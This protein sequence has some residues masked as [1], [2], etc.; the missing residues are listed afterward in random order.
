[1]K[2]I[3]GAFDGLLQCLTF[4]MFYGF[5]VVVWQHNDVDFVRC[6]AI[7]APINDKRRSVSV[8]DVEPSR[9]QYAGSFPFLTVGD[10][11]Y[12]TTH[13]ARRVSDFSSNN[14]Y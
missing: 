2:Q 4:G 7:E 14:M 3:N 13:D 10:G 6:F 5:V 1:M 12:S 11:Q 8:N 9:T